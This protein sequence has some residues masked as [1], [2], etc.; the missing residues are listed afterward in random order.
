[1]NKHSRSGAGWLSLSYAGTTAGGCKYKCDVT[2]NC[3][4]F[5]FRLSST[6]SDSPKNCWL[7]QSSDYA[8]SQV[9]DEDGYDIFVR[10]PTNVCLPQPLYADVAACD[11]MGSFDGVPTVRDR[12]TGTIAAV[13]SAEG[14]PEEQLTEAAVCATMGMAPVDGSSLHISSQSHMR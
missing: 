2:P 4:F 5:I 12:T 1:M 10:K 14:S 3:D 11:A 7:Y 8:W 13:F 6:P 9:V